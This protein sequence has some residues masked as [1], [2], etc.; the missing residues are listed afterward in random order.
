VIRLIVFVKSGID[1][2]PNL[3]VIF[4]IL[5]L[6]SPVLDYIFFGKGNFHL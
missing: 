4:N 1:L 6:I 2:G 5:K 3:W